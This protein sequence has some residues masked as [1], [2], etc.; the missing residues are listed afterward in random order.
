MLLLF[1]STFLYVRLNQINQSLKRVHQLVVAGVQE[2]LTHRS[3]IH[4]LADDEIRERVRQLSALIVR[5]LVKLPQRLDKYLWISYLPFEHVFC[6]AG[7]A[8]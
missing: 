3:E 1:Y 4:P 2:E 7:Y 8:R 5:C 6:Y